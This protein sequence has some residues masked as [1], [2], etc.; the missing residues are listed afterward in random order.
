VSHFSQGVTIAF[1]IRCQK[2]GGKERL[3]YG[4][5]SSMTKGEI[6]GDRLSLMSKRCTQFV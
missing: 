1:V 2:G 3:L 5:F 4:A 6:D